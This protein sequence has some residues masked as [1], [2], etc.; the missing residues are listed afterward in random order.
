M[1]DTTEK[2]MCR[3]IKTKH[4]V[5]N[6]QLNILNNNDP[7]NIKN[8]RFINTY[9][10]FETNCLVNGLF[11]DDYDDFT[12]K[13]L[14]HN[15]NKNWSFVE[16]TDPGCVLGNRQTYKRKY[17]SDG[18]TGIETT[19]DCCTKYSENSQ[20][21][22]L[23]CDPDKCIDSST[24]NRNFSNYCG[25]AVEYYAKKIKEEI[26]KEKEN[27]YL[28]NN[29]GNDYD[30]LLNQLN[31]SEC[32]P[33]QCSPGEQN[34]KNQYDFSVETYQSHIED[35]ILFIIDKLDDDKLP[36]HR[37]TK[38]IN[39]LKT[40]GVI[41]I[42]ENNKNIQN[43]LREL[44]NSDKLFSEK[45]TD[46]W[47]S[48]K[49]IYGPICNCFWDSYKVNNNPAYI[50][51]NNINNLK[52]MDNL[53]EELKKYIQTSTDIDTNLSNEC[54]FGDCK[55]KS[56]TKLIPNSFEC[57]KMNIAT[58]LSYASIE[59]NGT[60]NADNIEIYAECQANIDSQKL[61][62]EN[63]DIKNDINSCSQANYRYFDK[64][65]FDDD[66]FQKY[67]N[68]CNYTFNNQAN[69]EGECQFCEENA[70]CFNKNNVDK[71]N[72]K[73]CNIK[74]M[75]DTSSCILTGFE[76]ISY[77]N[78]KCPKYNCDKFCNNGKFIE[79][80]MTSE[81]INKIKSNTCDNIINY[82]KKYLTNMCDYIK[83]TNKDNKSCDWCSDID[84]FIK[85]KT[86]I[87][88]ND[89]EIEDD[90]N[91]NTKKDNK[92]NKDFLYYSI[93]IIFVILIIACCL[94]LWYIFS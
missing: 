54:W 31:R 69:I 67:K 1:T 30:S 71:T 32:T 8:P 59:N 3:N 15:F 93:G 82:D 40:R 74:D 20:E 85:S 76:D 92:E 47:N 35:F 56:K 19:L 25:Q 38:Y 80:Y 39:I 29:L 5:N 41:L 27:E 17:K 64:N 75:K 23:N 53:P 58:C 44:C 45:S 73:P 88:D 12:K 24:C 70:T 43:A 94:G 37:R 10:K 34:C 55:N 21:Q 6:R 49:Q 9:D 90:P 11:D 89:K 7:N 28:E 63:I 4:G 33:G 52:T 46:E 48:L 60:I 91:T 2:R 13:M 16:K 86:I 84:E 61:E 68:Y 42:V 66:L 77:L 50:N 72:N 83:K 57:P 79:D 51:R 18:S 14:Q 22:L 78:D 81:D 36:E 26:T 62:L 87:D 65:N